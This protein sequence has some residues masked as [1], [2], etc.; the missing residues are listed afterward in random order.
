MKKQIPNILT[1][2][3]GISTIIIAGLF[4]SNIESKFSI[5]YILFI[6]AAISDFFDGY[7][8]RKWK[9]AT[10]LGSILDPLFDKLLV[11]SL[12]LLI[13]SLNIIPG[14]LILILFARDIIIDSM[15]SFML[16]H[17][18]V[19]PA[20]KTAKIKTASQMLAL[21]FALLFLV[22]PQEEL[23]KEIAIL[24]GFV[25]TIFSIWSAAIYYK[26]FRIFF[27]QYAQK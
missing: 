17:G 26:K 3:R 4:L 7:L 18:T 24:L 15:R 14:F 16:S 11:L 25:A 21:H 27:R 22:F 2:F 19:V 6:F 1:F 9:V 23:L 10:E 12:F 13:F 8:A 5:I 20:I